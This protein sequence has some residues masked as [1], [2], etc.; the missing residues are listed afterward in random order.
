MHGGKLSIQILQLMTD[1]LC[2]NF[3]IHKWIRYYFLS[4]GVNNFHYIFGK[5][6]RIQQKFVFERTICYI[7][8]YLKCQYHARYA[9]FSAVRVMCASRAISSIVRQTIRGSLGRLCIWILFE[10]NCCSRNS[11]VLYLKKCLK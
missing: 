3:K 6:F 2:F 7:H 11:L 1:N 4:N 9:R 5:V 10:K 8:R